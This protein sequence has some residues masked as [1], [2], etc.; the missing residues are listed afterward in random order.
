MDGRQCGSR[1]EAD[2]VSVPFYCS[3]SATPPN[4]PQQ[5]SETSRMTPNLVC[6]LSDEVA[7]FSAAQHSAQLGTNAF[8]SPRSFGCGCAAL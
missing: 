4:G 1:A 6:P 5:S 8:I 2:I 7:P 3:A